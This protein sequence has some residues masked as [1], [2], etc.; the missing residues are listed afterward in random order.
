M[1]QASP[2]SQFTGD[3][4][5]EG[6]PVKGF[7]VQVPGVAHK[8]PPPQAVPFGKGVETQVPPTHASAVQPFPSSHWIGTLVQAP[9]AGSQWSAVQAS[10]SSHAA[11]PWQIGT[12]VPGMT[13][14][15]SPVVHGSPS[16]HD[17]PLSGVKVQSPLAGLH[18]SWV[19]GLPSSHTFGWLTQAPVAGSQ[20]PGAHGVPPHTTGVPQEPAWHVLPVVHGL[21]SSHAW[22][23][24]AGW[25][26]HWPPAG[27]Q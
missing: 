24:G 27:S 13:T 26:W 15:T 23:S 21:P 2:S 6:A 16:S 19:H 4:L 12:P 3:A 18:A 14:Q 10:P 1:V 11:T 25:D 17:E 22:P 5:H 20:T 7:V 8:S 9:V